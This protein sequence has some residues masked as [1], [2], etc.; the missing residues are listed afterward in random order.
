MGNRITP[1]KALEL[2]QNA[3]VSTLQQMALHVRFKAHP[4]KKVSYVLD[5]NPNYTNICTIGCSFCAFRRTA[6]ES[7]AFHKTVSEVIAEIR[8]AY[9]AGLTTVLLQGGI[10]PQVTLP[11]LVELVRRTKE[12]FPTIDAHFFSA[13]EI[14][15][16]AKHSNI[17]LEEALKQ[18]F[19]AGQRTIPNFLRD[20]K[21]IIQTI[22]YKKGSRKLFGNYGIYRN[23]FTI[24]Q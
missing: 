20:H 23:I 22:L 1:Q 14:F 7:G 11:Y 5:T 2:F 16:A 6:Q 17:P 8:A 15:Y 18:L 19:E 13:P 3:P 9:E 10:H 21:E 12:E 24:Y 4:S